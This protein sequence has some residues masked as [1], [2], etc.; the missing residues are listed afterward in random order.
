MKGSG[1]ERSPSQP[2]MLLGGP[3][4]SSSV[5]TPFTNISKSFLMLCFSCVFNCLPLL[6][7]LYFPLCIC[8][9]LVVRSLAGCVEV[10]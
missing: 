2:W 5:L 8:G 10:G 6:F 4:L 7:N 1:E 9:G 3:T